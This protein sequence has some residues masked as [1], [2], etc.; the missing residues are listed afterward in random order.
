MKR[1]PAPR[2]SGNATAANSPSSGAIADA[3]AR[4]CVFPLIP[5]FWLRPHR[6]GPSPD[7][8]PSRRM[9]R[10]HK[11]CLPFS[12]KRN[13][14]CCSP[15]NR[16][17]NAQAT[18]RSIRRIIKESRASG[19][20]LESRDMPLCS[21][22][23]RRL[24]PADYIIPASPTCRSKRGTWTDLS[25]TRV[26]SYRR[27]RRKRPFGAPRDGSHLHAEGEKTDRR[28]FSWRLW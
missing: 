23:R 17:P 24:M 22:A 20:S 14:S 11:A 21:P 12:S 15:P 26:V 3:A 6:R 18:V 8:G 7:P 5:T 28:H 10:R 13:R 9:T 19:K 25:A 27:H 4:R 16:T 2:R 1:R